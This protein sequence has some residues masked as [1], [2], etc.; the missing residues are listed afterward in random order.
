[1]AQR[2]SDLIIKR[3]PTPG[4]DSRVTFDD[5]VKGFG[6][7][8]TAAGSRAFVVYYRRKA[9]GRQR[10]VTIGSFPDWT[11]AAAREEAKRIKREV[12]SGADPVGEQQATRTAPTIADLAARFEQ[13]YLPRKRSSTQRVYKQQIMADILPALGMMKVAAVSH[14]DVDSFHRKLSAR[15][16][17]AAN[18]V[19]AVLSKM[20][21]L[22]V[23]WGWRIDNPCKG[24][25]RNQE[26][27]RTRYLS[28]PELA[29]LSAALAQLRDQNAANAVRLLLLTGARRGE[30]L[31]ARW[32]DIDVEAGV[33]IKPGATTKQ[34]TEHRVPLSEA[35]CQLLAEMRAQAGD[36]AD[37]IFPASRGGG[38]RAH[39]NQAWIRLRK[40]AKLGGARLHDL[41]HTYASVL[42]S[43]GLSLPVIGA[44]L[45]HST[46]TTTARYAHL[47]DDPLRAATERAS[48]ILTAKPAAEIVR[49]KK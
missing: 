26:H 8:I 32:G 47:F 24:I 12:D 35:A 27:K 41:R 22:A 37:W 25:E 17:T 4:R 16:P 49:L 30:L 7:R 45:G 29:R 11:T 2:L 44:L 36:A 34:K 5:A 9:D 10:R 6:I 28:G 42:A 3:L 15:A 33:W 13:D 21:S 19:L 46:P 18:R 43:A 40:A 1:L 39:I 20:F 48:A 14:A 31:A 38:Q 23:R